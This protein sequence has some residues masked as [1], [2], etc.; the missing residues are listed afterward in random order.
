MDSL[1]N[2]RLKHPDHPRVSA[3]SSVIIMNVISNVLGNS[4]PGVSNINR[5]KNERI[6]NAKKKSENLI[7]SINLVVEIYFDLKMAAKTLSEK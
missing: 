1:P 6:Y 4:S 3:K 5:N 2:F 7:I